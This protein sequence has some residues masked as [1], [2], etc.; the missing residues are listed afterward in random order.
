MKKAFVCPLSDVI[1]ALNI[2][3]PSVTVAEGEKTKKSKRT[4]CRPQKKKKQTYTNECVSFPS[5]RR[6]C[7]VFISFFFFKF[8]SVQIGNL[9]FVSKFSVPPS[10]FLWLRV[11]MI[12]VQPKRSNNKNVVICK[13]PKYTHCGGCE[14]SR[15]TTVDL[16]PL[17][18]FGLVLSPSHEPSPS[19]RLVTC[20][21]VFDFRFFI[22]GAHTQTNSWLR[23]RTAIE[24]Y[25]PICSVHLVKVVRL[26]AFSRWIQID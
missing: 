5:N 14:L 9:V 1:L 22:F 26:C 16:L 4:A 15:A 13:S 21:R 18:W 17:T 23:H 6:C 25:T 10:V 2:V 19:G 8:I 24:N 12:V 7:F 3:F 20:D 11:L